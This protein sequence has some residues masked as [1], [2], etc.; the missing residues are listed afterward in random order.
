MKHLGILT[1][2]IV[3][4][5]ASGCAELDALRERSAAQDQQIAR[6]QEENRQFNDAYYKIKETL[7]GEMGKSG[8]RITELERELEKARN[9]KS[10]EEKSLGDKLRT[11]QLEYQAFRDEATEKDA[12]AQSTIR[13]LNQKLG[14][15]DAMVEAQKRRLR[16]FDGQ[17]KDA[18]RR[19]D[20]L[21]KEL[22]AIKVAAQQSDERAASL[23]KEMKK[24]ESTREEEGAA[25]KKMKD[26]LNIEKELREAIESERDDLEKEVNALKSAAAEA[27]KKFKA[28][29]EKDMEKL[30]AELKPKSLS[31]DETLI[32]MVTALRKGVGD[33]YADVRL[34]LDKSGLRVM[35][36][37]ANLFGEGSV[38]LGDDGRVIVKA[39]APQLVRAGEFVIRVE[40]HTGTEPVPSGLPFP[41]NWRLGFA[42]AESVREALV[43]AAGLPEAQLIPL[44]RA[45]VDPPPD[46]GPADRVEIVV[47]DR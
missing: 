19:S 34:R 37:A 40:G 17:L 32:S 4:L 22:A 46:G 45:G 8:K 21:T 29:H 31:E 27:E 36:P 7:D 30:R 2:L 39:L 38:A 20:E 9:L 24:L 5:T 33:Q 3:G 18:A 44:S 42:R 15:R 16:D 1:L 35:I 10:Q 25:L 28:S 12:S 41:D 26:D 6:L 11:T 43:S 47:S 23:E 14:E 13:D